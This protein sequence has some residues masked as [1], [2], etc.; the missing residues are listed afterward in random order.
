M[1]P[2]YSTSFP[3]SANGSVSL[4]YVPEKQKIETQLSHQ[5]KYINVQ[6]E[7]THQA[8][9][10]LNKQYDRQNKNSIN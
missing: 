4:V 1:K 2:K 7:Y 6:Y 8:L 9:S 10:I 3:D 5:I